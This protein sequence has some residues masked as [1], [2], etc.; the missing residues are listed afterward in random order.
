[1]ER[2]FLFANPSIIEGMARVLDLGATL[3]EYNI[4]QSSQEADIAAIKSDWD[5]VGSDLKSVMEEDRERLVAN[6]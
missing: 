4:S 1:M 3:N 2:Y 5:A 6:G